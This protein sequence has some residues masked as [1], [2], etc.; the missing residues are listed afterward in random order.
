MVQ[1][2]AHGGSY[3]C[4]GMSHLSRFGPNPSREQI[5]RLILDRIAAVPGRV[6][7]HGNAP[8][9]LDNHLFE[10]VLTDNQM[11]VGWAAVLKEY[12]FRFVTRCYNSN[13]GNYINVLHYSPTRASRRNA[14]LPFDWPR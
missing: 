3:S 8:R 7:N 10:A 9:G 4:C 14:D 13:T 1:L 12:G 5:D 11:Q 6:A 2:T